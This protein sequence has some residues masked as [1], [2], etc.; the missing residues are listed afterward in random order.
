MKRKA[1]SAIL[2]LALCLSLL[3]VA[4]LA[5]DKVEQVYDVYQGDGFYITA[6]P[7]TLKST[8]YTMGN[9]HNYNFDGRF[10]DGMIAVWTDDVDENYVNRQFV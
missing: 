3:P 9:S 1:L 4:A 8:K 2:I 6:K 7:Y 5:D 10:H